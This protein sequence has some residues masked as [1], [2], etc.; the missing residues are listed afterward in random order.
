MNLSKLEKILDYKFR[1]PSLLERAITHRSWAHENLPGASEEKLREAENESLEFVGDSVLGLVIAEQLYT[2][3]PTLSEGD[4]T[5]MK[6]HLVSMATL[7]K[8]ALELGLGEFVRVGR[9]EEKT[10]GRKKQAILADTLEAIIAAIFFDGGYGTAKECVSK[11]FAA[12]L[13]TVTPKGSLDYKTLLQET[14][15]SE[16]LSAPSYVLVKTDGQP[17]ARTFFV[18]AVWE[19][20]RSEGTGRSIKS[21]EMMA[22]SE[23][24]KMLRGKAANETK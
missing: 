18:E 2:A 16:K 13:G 1:E 21:A 20:G 14:L 23:A 3:N 24:L 12:D 4:L 19:T 15:Q 8:L 17:H 9:G 22:A 6:H 11:I 10:G 5:L 7:A